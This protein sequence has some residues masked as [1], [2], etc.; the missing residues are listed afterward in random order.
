M[1]IQTHTYEE[2]YDHSI[3]YT[4]DPTMHT[5]DIDVGDY[6]D[7]DDSDGEGDGGFGDDYNGNGHGDGDVEGFEDGNGQSMPADIIKEYPFLVVSSE[8]HDMVEDL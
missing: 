2:N 4:I 3:D 5:G 6:G 8:L 7:G 1:V